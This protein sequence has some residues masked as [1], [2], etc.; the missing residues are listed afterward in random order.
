VPVYGSDRPTPD[1][2]CVRDFVHVSDLAEA[3]VA[4]LRHL[5]ATGRSVTL[6]CGYGRGFSVRPPERRCSFSLDLSG[7]PA[8]H[9]TALEADGLTVLVL[10]YNEAASIA[11]TILSVQRQTR[12]PETIIVLE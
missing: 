11:D 9:R 12:P 6:N 7:R 3:H 8:C 2:T 10:A 4:A 5:L 1:G